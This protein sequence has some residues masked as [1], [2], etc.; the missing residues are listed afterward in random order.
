MSRDWS[1]KDM[2]PR[3]G[4][5]VLVTGGYGGIG[6]HTALALGR[7]G[8][9]VLVAGRDLARGNRALADLRAAAPGASFRFEPLDLASLASVRELAGRVLAESSG[10]DVLVAN[11]GVMAVPTRELT[12]DG[13]ERQL[14]TNH[15]GHFALVGLLLRALARSDAPRVVTVS[16]GM[17]R[18]ARIDLDDL[19]SARR[20]RPMRAYAQSKLANL[21]F[22]HELGRRVPWLVSV[23]AHPGGARTQLQRYDWAR[24]M[25]LI[26][27][28][29]ADGALPSL[30]AIVDPVPSGTYFGPR[31]WLHMRGAP[32]IVPSPRRALDGELARRLWEASEA[33]TGVRYPRATPAA[34]SPPDQTAAL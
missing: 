6:Y 20:Y 9:Q 23:A 28:S 21:L 34:A 30:R 10:I 15:L 8:A 31:A 17:A 13:F 4:Q 27:Q 32:V 25:K 14:G 11:A 24:V 18:L 5:R 2:G 26:G 1:L 19:Q 16:S 33:L 12:V 7:A 29:A 22:A 3:A